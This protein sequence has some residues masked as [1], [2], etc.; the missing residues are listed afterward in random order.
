MKLMRLIL[1]RRASKPETLQRLL[2]EDDSE[3]R[4]NRSS[5]PLRSKRATKVTTQRREDLT[6]CNTNRKKGKSASEFQSV[7]DRYCLFCRR[8]VNGRVLL[9]HLPLTLVQKLQP[10]QGSIERGCNFQKRTLSSPTS[11]N[12]KEAFPIEKPT[13]ARFGLTS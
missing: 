7:W 1:Y 12:P 9:P 5:R 6:K 2:F 8:K 4:E 3:R 10:L 13:S 11:R